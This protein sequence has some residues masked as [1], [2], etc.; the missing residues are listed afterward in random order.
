MVFQC[1]SQRDFPT[2][3]SL[4]LAIVT[5]FCTYGSSGSETS[6]NLPDVAQPVEWQDPHSAPEFQVLITRTSP[7]T[8]V[9]SGASAG[10]GGGYRVRVIGRGPPH[11]ATVTSQGSHSSFLHSPLALSEDR[12]L[13]ASCS[14]PGN[15]IYKTESISC[16]IFIVG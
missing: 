2:T 6:S 10:K 3:V 14:A 11:S 8:Q 7:H 16:P 9:L 15:L 12:V 13:G 5:P 1:F 4:I